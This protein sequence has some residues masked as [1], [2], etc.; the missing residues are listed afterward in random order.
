MKWFYAY[1]KTNWI[2]VGTYL[3]CSHPW[4]SFIQIRYLQL[5]SLFLGSYLSYIYRIYCIRYKLT[6]WNVFAILV[7]FISNLNLLTWQNKSDHIK[8]LQLHLQT[9]QIKI[10]CWIRCILLTFVWGLNDLKRNA[11]QKKVLKMFEVERKK[12]KLQS[13]GLGTWYHSLLSTLSLQMRT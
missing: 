5:A 9:N 13:K 11:K 8:R 3:I 7:N 6:C 2:S 12:M 4:F 10:Y 1:G